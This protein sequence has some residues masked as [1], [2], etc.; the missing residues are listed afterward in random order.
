VR[1]R[2]LR[3]KN[4]AVWGLGAEGWS[5]LK[6]IRKKFPAATITVINDAALSQ[7]MEMMLT[8]DPF[9]K[10]LTGEN[11]AGSLNKFDVIIKSPGISAYRPEIKAAKEAGVQFTSATKLWFAEHTEDKTVCITGTKGK[12]TTSSLTTHLLRNA[13][14]RVTLGGNIGTP[15]L[16]MLEVEPKPDVWVMEM[17]SYQISDLDV[18]PSIAVLLNLFPEH[19]DWHGNVDNYYKDKLNLFAHQTEN[20]IS[21]INKL[22]KNTNLLAPDFKNTIYFNDEKGMHIAD[23]YICDGSK[24]LFPVDRV[25]IPGNHNLSNMCA[26]LTVVKALDIDPESCVEALSTFKGLPHRL[27]PWGT[28]NDVLYV[29]DSISTT[30]QSAMAAIDTYPGRPVT[31]LLGGFDRGLNVDELA[32]YVINKPVHAVITMPDNGP[33]IAET[34]TKARAYNPD[35]KLALHESQDLQDAVRI[36]REITP[37]GGVILLSPGAPSYGRFKNFAERGDTFARFS[38][39]DVH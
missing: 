38:G 16:D 1:I 33:R 7:E 22:D 17:S 19:L 13:G 20:S 23:G 32:G 9:L 31:I 36:A 15:M 25:T 34:I 26:A 8:Q 39:F 35:S 2:E 24:K 3:D 28:I 12:S 27:F 6:T 11:I 30:P 5:T 18:S 10:L 14:I 21:I 37:A 29:D 4:I